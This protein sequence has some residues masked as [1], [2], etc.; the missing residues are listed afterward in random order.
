GTIVGRIKADIADDRQK[1]AVRAFIGQ[2]PLYPTDDIEEDEY[3]AQHFD[4]HQTVSTQ[5]R[6]ATPHIDSP[7]EEARGLAPTGTFSKRWI[8]VTITFRDEPLSNHVSELIMDSYEAPY[9]HS[10][11]PAVQMAVYRAV[12]DFTEL[13][14]EDVH[15]PYKLAS[16][17][18]KNGFT[19][20]SPSLPL[21]NGWTPT[22]A[23]QKTRKRTDRIRAT[24]PVLLPQSVK[25][26][27]PNIAV[28]QALLANTEYTPV[29]PSS[30]QANSTTNLPTATLRA[31]HYT[32]E[33][34]TTHPATT[35]DR[36]S[37]VKGITLEIDLLSPGTIETIMLDVPFFLDN[38]RPTGFT[39]Q[40]GTLLVVE[41]T[42][43]APDETIEDIM[44]RIDNVISRAHEEPYRTSLIL[45]L[46]GAE[47][48]SEAA[49]SHIASR[50]LRYLQGKEMEKSITPGT[51]ARYGDYVVTFSPKDS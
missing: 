45:M 23:P 37:L 42:T 19:P 2:K 26:N 16:A 27:Q 13:T 18:E 48:A 4:L 28:N 40:P 9:V 10:L 46:H 20:K 50:N 25:F 8:T 7:R 49:L 24:Q 30:E 3:Y 47:R 39:G 22:P 14:P 31:V 15:I 32:A 38:L 43:R 6:L 1:Y 5:V 21:Y 17:M 12:A 36:N 34:G 29:M 11:L 44:T 41:D 35:I 33:D 51:T